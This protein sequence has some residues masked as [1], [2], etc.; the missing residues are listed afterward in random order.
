MLPILFTVPMPWGPQPIYSYGVSLGVSLVIG[1]QLVLRAA[2]R[3]GLDEDVASNAALIAALTGLAGARLLYVAENREL[4]EDTGASF[5]DITSGG[6]TAYGGFLG[7]LLGA[8]AYLFRK[9]VSLLAFGD[10]AGP[11][12]GLG[13]AV[14]RI[15]CYLYGCDFGTVLSDSAPRWLARLGTFP[16]WHYDRLRLQ[17]SPAFLYHVDRYGLSRDASASLPVHPTQLYEGLGGL[18]LM[19]LALALLRRRQFA[20][21]VILVVAMGY[22]ASRFVFEYLRDDP[23]RG[24]AFGFSSAQLISI[25]LVPLCAVAYSILRGKARRAAAAG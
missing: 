14:T 25:L 11:A 23:E 8:G 20:G 6:V 2:R 5:I 18:A 22:G 7:G 4:L 12:L 19:L 1:F 15:G 17:G 10:A 24:F 21:Q 13:T 9:R 16:H 3:T